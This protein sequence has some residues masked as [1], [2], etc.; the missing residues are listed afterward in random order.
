MTKAALITRDYSLILLGLTTLLAK[1]EL[2]E[3]TTAKQHTDMLGK[4]GSVISKT[5]T[6]EYDIVLVPLHHKH[7]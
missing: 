6:C 2:L 5:V 1:H 4:V 3:T 7:S